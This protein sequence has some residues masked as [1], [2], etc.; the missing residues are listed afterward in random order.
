MAHRPTEQ[1][2]IEIESKVQK[3]EGLDVVVQ[4]IT[5]K[6]IKKG[7]SMGVPQNSETTS[8]TTEGNRKEH[9]EIVH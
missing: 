2:K 4:R 3:M 8:V 6:G 1:S 9:E 5:S 7:I